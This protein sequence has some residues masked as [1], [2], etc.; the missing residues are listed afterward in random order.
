MRRQGTKNLVTLLLETPINVNAKDNNWLTPLHYAIVR[1]DKEIIEALEAAGAKH[2]APSSTASSIDGGNSPEKQEVEPPPVFGA[3]S[4]LLAAIK[5][6]DLSLCKRAHEEGADLSFSFSECKEGKCT[7]LLF[8]IDGH[9]NTGKGF[10]NRCPAIAEFL[11]DQ[12]V[13][14][15]AQSCM[16]EMLPMHLAAARGQDTVIRKLLARG[17][18]TKTRTLE[19]FHLA[20][21]HGNIDAI[22]VLLE[23]E[24]SIEGGSK[25]RLLNSQVSSVDAVAFKEYSD[26]TERKLLQEPYSGSAMHIAAYMGYDDIL[27]FLIKE[28]ADV[29]SLNEYNHIPLMHAIW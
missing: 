5:Q 22:K 9:K 8:A 18:E 27:E 2:V 6:R 10:F 14:I 23:H 15:N 16:S 12:D 1:G 3:N 7:P 21:M 4:L 13:D 28:G 11:A 20:I 29:D 26:F 17:A 19:A 25:Q 24:E